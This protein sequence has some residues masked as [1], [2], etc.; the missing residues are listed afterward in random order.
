MRVPTVLRTYHAVD[1]EPVNAWVVLRKTPL[2]KL[3]RFCFLFVRNQRTL[4]P[5]LS[6]RPGSN[7]HRLIKARPEVFKVVLTSYVAANWD[8][9]TRIERLLDHY[10]T[11][12]EIGGVVDFPPD[13]LVDIVPL[14]VINPRYRITLDQAR[15]LLHEGSLTMSLCDG[16][17]R[18]FHLSFNLST[19]N[20]KRIAYIG[21]LQGRAE[22]DMYNYKIDI[23]D[24]YRA[25]T[26]AASGMRPRDF[27]VEVFRLFCKALG[28]VEIRAVSDINH[29]QRRLFSDV[30]LSYDQ[31][32]V[33]RGGASAGN[34][35]FILPAVAKRRSGKEIPSK[36]RKMYAKRYA[37]LDAV[38]AQLVTVL[39][40]DIVLV[41]QTCSA[42][43]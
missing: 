28:V 5:M 17:D 4:W 10:R 16:I 8:V 21:S 14:T 31:I 41:P 32:W 25:F 22:I 13:I 40:S 2:R 29:P 24:R 43:A 11:V 20:G 18:V 42:A 6:A 30:H 26:K 38:E 9:R 27:L 39:N 37:M 19:E 1:R 7:L 12:A 3:L 36:K 15:W 34:G 35:F 33:E 23:L